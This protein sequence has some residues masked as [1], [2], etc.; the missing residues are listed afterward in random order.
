[1]KTAY[2]LN[3]HSFS[4][5]LIGKVRVGLFTLFFFLVAATTWAQSFAL[6]ELRSDPRKAYG[7][8]Y[9]YSFAKS[10]SP[11][12]RKAI[13]RSISAIMAA[14]VLAITGATGSI[15]SSTRC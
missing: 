4:P 5:S 15:M 12:P 14:T 9:P 13:S 2:S 1:M 7:T 3:H 10:N 8:D 6:D 11:K